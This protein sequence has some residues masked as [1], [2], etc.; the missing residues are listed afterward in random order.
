VSPMRGPTPK[1]EIQEEGVKGE[2][3]ERSEKKGEIK[4]Q[5]SQRGFL[6]KPGRV[7]ARRVV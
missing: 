2:K 1:S 6:D 7:P 3:K 5:T 4:Q